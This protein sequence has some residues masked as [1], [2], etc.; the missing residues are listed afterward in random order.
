MK[1]LAITGNTLRR[2][3]RDRTALFFMI[4]LPFFIILIVGSATKNLS[5]AGLP[6]GAVC[7]RREF[8]KRFCDDRPADICFARGTFNSHP[9]VMGAMHA[10][11]SHLE[12]P[13]A[14]ELYRD[15]DLLWDGRAQRLNERLR[16]TSVDAA[17][18]GAAAVG[19]R[20]ISGNFQR[21]ND[22]P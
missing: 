6:V 22:L 10:F 15:L 7:G 4:I 20:K 17:R 14:H 2:I 5:T 16:G 3:S 19:R 13:Q 8:M 12:T 18:T 9:Y 21:S 1:A 11:L